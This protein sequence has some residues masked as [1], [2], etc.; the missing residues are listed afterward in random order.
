AQYIRD[1]AF[2]RGGRNPVLDVIGLLLVAPAAGLGHRA[3]DRP[4]FTI[5]IKDHPAI[6][7]AGGAA[8]GLNKRRFAAQKTFLVGV[9]NGDKGAFWNVEPFP[10]KIDPDEHIESAEPQIADDFDPLDRVDVGV[11]V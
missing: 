8:D 3:L 11:H 7:I 9:E 4:G 6:D 1:A 5:G 10:Q 2:D